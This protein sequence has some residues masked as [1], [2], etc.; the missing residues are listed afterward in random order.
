IS[1]ASGCGA[2]QGVKVVALLVPHF[3]VVSHQICDIT[4]RH[5][6]SERL[7]VW[8]NGPGRDGWGMALA[9]QSAGK[10]A[11]WSNGSLVSYGR[12]GPSD[13]PL[14]T[15]MSL[16]RLLFQRS[17]E[18]IDGAWCAYWR[19][20]TSTA[21]RTRRRLGYR[22]LDEPSPTAIEDSNATTTSSSMIITRMGLLGLPPELIDDVLAALS[23]CDILAT[24]LTC[25]VLDAAI[26]ASSRIQY[27]LECAAAGVI[28]DELPGGPPHAERLTMLKRREEAWRLARPV[29]QSRIGVDF[30]PSS[31]YDFTA[32]A[33]VLGWRT[34]DGRRR[35]GA[36]TSTMLGEGAHEDGNAWKTVKMA[37]EVVDFGLAVLEHD[38]NAVLT[39]RWELDRFR[40]IYDLHFIRFSTSAPH[41]GAREPVVR[42]CEAN[43]SF[44]RA[45]TLI[46]I[47]GPLLVILLVFPT[48]VGR[49]VD[50]LYVVEW[51][52]GAVHKVGTFTSHTYSSLV[53][54]DPTT[55]L[56]PDNLAPTLN[57]MRLVRG[58]YGAFALEPLAVL[59]LPPLR[60]GATAH[61]TACRAEP[62]PT[63]S[64]LAHTRA[65]SRP[66]R[67]DPARALVLLHVSFVA[68]PPAGNAFVR[69]VA[70]LADRAAL[71]RHAERGGLVPYGVWGEDARWIEGAGGSWI[72]H[73]C[74]RRHVYLGGRR[75]DRLRVC[76][77]NPV[78]VRRERARV[79]EE[80]E[81][82]VST[83]LSSAEEEG[84]RVDE[85]EEGEEEEEEEEDSGY[86]I[87]VVGKGAA[88]FSD[89]FEGPV[90]SGLEYV[91]STMDDRLAEGSAGLWMD[92]ERVLVIQRDGMRNVSAIDVLTFG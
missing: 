53:F 46:E 82:L 19:S 62:N 27:V 66:F 45:M 16:L 92:E 17:I 38:L 15:T 73:A 78:A 44:E 43:A 80:R 2:R 79:E 59:C 28:D 7:V 6:N 42:V 74:G 29:R 63:P 40:A 87:R 83:S 37:D 1:R 20:M 90:W 54:L 22:T 91:E 67:D 89:F 57:V 30:S 31:L 24:R 56:L 12:C 61:T 39:V 5:V 10:D 11:S 47:V 58:P 65:S 75:R 32:G 84:E 18:R 8:R 34:E 25:K 70:L 23:S 48:I 4:V 52:T 72:T 13:Y 60:D 50:E 86:G 26:R 77:F 55:L 76:D 69:D 21:I 81:R 41:E 68:F 33:V 9:L 71:R 49:G 14:T 35:T 85:E 3:G 88:E 51:Q 36:L 64:G